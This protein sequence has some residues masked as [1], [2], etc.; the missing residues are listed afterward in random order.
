MDSNNRAKNKIP[1]LDADVPTKKLF[2]EDITNFLKENNLDWTA[3]IPHEFTS[4]YESSLMLVSNRDLFYKKGYAIG[5]IAEISKVGLYSDNLENKFIYLIGG[6]NIDEL[7]LHKEHYNLQ[8]KLID[9]GFR[10]N[11]DSDFLGFKTPVKT[12]EQIYTTI[13]NLEKVL[14][15]DNKKSLENAGEQK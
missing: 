13:K 5:E 11:Y 2:A 7:P 4:I 15:D 10:K 3:I 1:I 9:A 12:Y 6:V 8:R 14:S